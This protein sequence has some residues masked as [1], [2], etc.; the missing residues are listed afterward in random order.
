MSTGMMCFILFLIMLG[1]MALDIFVFEKEKK[2]GDKN[3]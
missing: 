3:E 1:S 2:K